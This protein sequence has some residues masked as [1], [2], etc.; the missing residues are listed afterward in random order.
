MRFKLHE[1]DRAALGA[2]EWIEFDESVMRVKEIRSIHA[3]TGLRQTQWGPE[4]E[5]AN[6]DLI[7]AMV[8]VALRRA[9]VEVAYQDLDFDLA[10]MEIDHTGGKA[11]TP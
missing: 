6:I 8:Q 10:G 7:A 9:G 4:L 11:P 2:P 1:S 3:A 5:A